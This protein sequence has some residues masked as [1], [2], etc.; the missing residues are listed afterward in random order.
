MR[1]FSASIGGNPR[2]SKTL[3]LV[4]IMIVLSVVEVDFDNAVVLVR[5]LLEMFSGFSFGRRVGR[6]LLPRIW[7]YRKYGRHLGSEFGFPPH[8]CQRSASV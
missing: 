2:S 4:V 6:R 7:Q 5:C 8:L 1:R 3:W